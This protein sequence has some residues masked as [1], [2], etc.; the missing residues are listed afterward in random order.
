MLRSASVRINDRF[1]QGLMCPGGRGGGRGGVGVGG[2]LQIT[3]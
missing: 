2:G 3:G 1:T